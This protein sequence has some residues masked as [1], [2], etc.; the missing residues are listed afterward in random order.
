MA[1]EVRIDKWLWAV[2]FYK[3]RNVSLKPAER[4]DKSQ[5]TTGETIPND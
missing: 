3:T 1:S 5:W 2:R 4:P